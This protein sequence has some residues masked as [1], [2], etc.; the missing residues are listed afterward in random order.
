VR[1]YFE[2]GCIDIIQPDIAHAGGISETRKIAIMAE[3]YDIGVAP[4]C[5]L[6]PLA[7]AASLQVGF[8][9]PNFVIC[10]MSWK[11]HYN[12]GGFD[13][14]TYMK[15][16]EVFEVRDGHIDLLTAPG[17]GVELNEELIRKE[18][19][20]AAKLEPWTNPLFRGPDGT[21]REW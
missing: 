15:N 8:S 1:P 10:E 16:P 4:H 21:V 6:G 13:L 7:F 18:A 5:P 20:E 3:A 17:L 9:T 11:M 19:A 12:T 2:A 14:L